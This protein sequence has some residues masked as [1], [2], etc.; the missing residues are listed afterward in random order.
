MVIEIV[1]YINIAIYFKKTSFSANWLFLKFGNFGQSL[2][3][4]IL[5]LA[6]YSSTYA[7]SHIKWIL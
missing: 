2:L 5:E 1:V 3:I 7:Y 6:V 4:C